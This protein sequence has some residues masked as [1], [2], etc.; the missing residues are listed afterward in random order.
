[1]IHNNLIE[2]MSECDS[3]DDNFMLGY[4][5]LELM[6]DLDEKNMMTFFCYKR[7]LHMIWMKNNVT[8]FVCL[9]KV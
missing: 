5:V 9:W 4:V 8:T 3:D 7:I 1:L 2:I 6:N